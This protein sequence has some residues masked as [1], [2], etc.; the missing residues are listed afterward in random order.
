MLG[1]VWTDLNTARSRRMHTNISTHRSSAAP[2]TRAAVLLIAQLY[3]TR[4]LEGVNILNRDSSEEKKV[5]ISHP[6]KLKSL[7]AS[8]SQSSAPLL[9]GR[10]ENNLNENDFVF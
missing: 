3:C 6:L 8:A 10:S 4:G 7:P 5:P 1:L 2:E 9:P